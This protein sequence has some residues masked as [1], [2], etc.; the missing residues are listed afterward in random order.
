MGENVRSFFVK[1]LSTFREAKT[2]KHQVPWSAGSS[3]RGWDSQESEQGEFG[4]SDNSRF[5]WQDSLKLER[6]AEN[7]DK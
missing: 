1:A 2:K 7:K 6:I 3:G 4:R 5:S